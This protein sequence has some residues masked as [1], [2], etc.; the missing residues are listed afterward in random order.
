[1]QNHTEIDLKSPGVLPEKN[2]VTPDNFLSDHR[3]VFANVAM[4]NE[5]LGV[6]SWNIQSGGCCY[7]NIYGK[8]IEKLVKHFIQ[9]DKIKPAN[10]FELRAIEKPEYGLSEE[11]KKIAR[12]IANNYQEELNTI[13]EAHKKYKLLEYYIADYYYSQR[14]RKQASLIPKEELDVIFLQEATKETVKVYLDALGKEWTA[15]HDNL[16]E[17]SNVNVTFIRTARFGVFQDS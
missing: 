17:Y 4:T 3:P 12:H 9:G 6:M 15:V 14:M 1:M 5:S 13:T 7:G 2:A 8:N 10:A 11:E 16:D